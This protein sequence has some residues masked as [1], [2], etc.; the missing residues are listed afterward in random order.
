MLYIWDEG[1]LERMAGTRSITSNLLLKLNT[2]KL[3][4]MISQGTQQKDL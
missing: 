2:P 1:L 3:S 4:H